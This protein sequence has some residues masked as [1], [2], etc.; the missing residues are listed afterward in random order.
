MTEANSLASPQP[1]VAENQDDRPSTSTG[2]ASSLLHSLLGQTFSDASVTPL[3]HQSARVIADEEMTR[4]RSTP[5]LSLSEDP[6]NRWHV[7]KVSF[8]LLSKMAKRYLCVPATSVSAERVFTTAVYI[9]TAQRRTLTPE[10]V[11]QLLF[12]HKNLNLAI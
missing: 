3:H 9:V 7:N 1:E 2:R 10:Y 6:L 4:Y 5:P 8:H 11:D 12:L